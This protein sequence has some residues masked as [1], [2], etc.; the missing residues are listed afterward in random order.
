MAFNTAGII[1]YLAITCRFVHNYI[2][3]VPKALLAEP[4]DHLVNNHTSKLVKDY[5]LQTASSVRELVL[6][7][8]S[9]LEL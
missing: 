9:T 7:R 6:I 3:V 5:H 1:H 2:T 4:V 8:V